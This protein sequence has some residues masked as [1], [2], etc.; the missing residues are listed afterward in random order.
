MM[1]SA[2]RRWMH[3]TPATVIATLALAFAMT[4]GAFAAG[5]Y[6]ITSTKQISPKVLK[7]LTGKAG[8]P[9]AQ[10]PAGSAGPVGPAGGPGP[11]GQEGKEGKQGEPGKEGKAGA[12]GTTGFT[13]TLPQGKTL[14]GDWGL[15]ASVAGTGLEGVVSTVVGFN[16]PLT[17]APAPHL[18]PAP[19]EAEEKKGEFPTPPAGCTGNVTKPG[20]APGNLCVFAR[21]QVNVSGEKICATGEAGEA[22]LPVACAS[23]GA[24]TPETADPYGFMLLGTAAAKGLIRDVGT[25]AVTSAK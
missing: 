18:I 20:A 3:V 9:G 8:A 11:Q 1:F 7:S 12:S 19:T 15:F 10:G 16:I 6:L 14:K 21:E 13:E 22:G 4:G 2:I 25:W 23:A 17:A 5:H 24:T